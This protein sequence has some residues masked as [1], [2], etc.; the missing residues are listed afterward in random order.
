MYK[1]ENF[2]FFSCFVPIPNPS[3]QKGREEKLNVFLSHSVNKS[4][5]FSLL[6]FEGRTQVGTKWG[7]MNIIF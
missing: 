7:K 4:T 2:T 6:H 3:L 1:N 5:G